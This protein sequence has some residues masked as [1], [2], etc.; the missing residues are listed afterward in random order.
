MK[1]VCKYDETDEKDV[2]SFAKLTEHA[3]AP[4]KGSEYAAGFDLKRWAARDVGRL[5]ARCPTD[6]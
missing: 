3:Y 1:K 5:K 2:L 4:F 6:C